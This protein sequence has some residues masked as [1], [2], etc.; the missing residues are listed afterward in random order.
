[1]RL[2]SADLIFLPLL[3]LL[4]GKDGSSNWSS[5]RELISSSAKAVD[6][7]ITG[8][9]KDGSSALSLHLPCLQSVV[10]ARDELHSA[11]QSLYSPWK[12][13]DAGEDRNSV[14]SDKSTENDICPKESVSNHSTVRNRVVSKVVYTLTPGLTAKGSPHWV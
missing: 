13:Q 3:I 10:T 5:C 1:M 6:E 7:L 9:S 12:K 11:L 4:P 14:A 8:L 2:A